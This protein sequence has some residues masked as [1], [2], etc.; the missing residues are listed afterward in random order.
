MTVRRAA[1][2]SLAGMF[3][4][5]IFLTGCIQ[6]SNKASNPVDTS[7][8]STSLVTTTV[9]RTVTS[10]VPRPVVTSPVSRLIVT[11]DVRLLLPIA[12]Y[13]E[14]AWLTADTF[15]IERHRITEGPVIFELWAGRPD[16]S[17]FR[18]LNVRT[19]AQCRLDDVH[20]P[21]RLGGGRLGA[22]RECSPKNADSPLVRRDTLVAVNVATG[23]LTWLASLG[24]KVVTHVAWDPGMQ[25]AIASI[26]SIA[27]NCGTLVSLTPSGTEPLDLRVGPRGHSWNTADQERAAPSKGACDTRYGTVGGVTG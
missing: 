7:E 17:D 24:D 23:A 14:I 19:G 5:A 1:T 26:T 4:A 22:V 8:V 12:D 10:T 25:H 20:H 2:L 13:G 27:S 11:G 21:Y 18:K 6:G 15:V 16:G 9:P 3:V